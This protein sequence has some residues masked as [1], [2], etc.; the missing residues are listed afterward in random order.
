[1]C[2]FAPSGS[3]RFQFGPNR[4]QLGPTPHLTSKE[5]RRHIAEGILKNAQPDV[6]MGERAKAAQLLISIANKGY[7]DCPQHQNNLARRQGNK[8][9]VLFQ[10][11]MPLGNP[12]MVAD[13]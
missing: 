13:P 10:I 1:M 8:E 12:L 3:N 11:G 7:Q 6:Q 2:H 5:G 9:T 4:F